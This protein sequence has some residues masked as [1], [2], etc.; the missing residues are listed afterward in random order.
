MSKDF[1]NKKFENKFIDKM[2]VIIV[3]LLILLGPP[4]CLFY[5]LNNEP[6]KEVFI[7]NAN[8]CILEQHFLLK[9]KNFINLPKPN[10]IEMEHSYGG[11]I[12]SWKLYSEYHPLFSSPYFI[13]WLAEK[14]KDIIETSNNKFKITK[15]NSLTLLVLMLNLFIIFII[16]YGRINYLRKHRR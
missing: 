2:L 10:Y 9:P 12:H 4:S 11:K 3:L 8:F 14:D 7:C 1:M 15:Y 16:L 13:P 5:F 6:V